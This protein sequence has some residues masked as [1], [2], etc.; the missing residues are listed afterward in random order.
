[1]KVNELAERAGVSGHAVRYYDHLG[2]LRCARD[3]ENS[4]RRFDMAALSRLRFI[5]RAKSLGFTLAEIRRILD[6][7][8]SK[9]S[10]CPAVREIV[11]RRIQENARRIRELIEL[12][13]RL[14]R[15]AKQWAGKP[16]RVPNGHAVCHLI[17]HFGDDA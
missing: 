9:E 7:G 17:E 3:P 16:N 6:M 1:M 5:H 4:Y 12:Q 13:G 8:E 11:H 15:A 10:P 2:L 14:E